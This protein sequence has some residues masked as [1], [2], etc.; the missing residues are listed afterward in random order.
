MLDGYGATPLNLTEKLH[1]FSRS[2]PTGI[3]VYAAKTSTLLA[4][5]KKVVE[6]FRI[7]CQLP[8]PDPE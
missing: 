2:R 3:V 5:D 4:A 6:A 8:R 7:Q 1:Y